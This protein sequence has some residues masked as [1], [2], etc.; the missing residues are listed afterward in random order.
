MGKVT[1]IKQQHRHY[2]ANSIKNEEYIVR[3][4]PWRPS[5]AKTRANA[6]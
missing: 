2:Q 4:F 5:F 6:A 3:V 1:E